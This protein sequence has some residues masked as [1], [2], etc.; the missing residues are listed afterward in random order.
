MSF[1]SQSHNQ[2]QSKMATR[3]GRIRYRFETRV[4]YG[5]L[6]LGRVFP[7]SPPSCMRREGWGVSVHYEYL[8]TLAWL[9]LIHCHLIRF[10]ANI[11]FYSV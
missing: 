4:G 10:E 8:Q 6:R 1:P 5:N 7:E 3:D 2:E 9:V 11:L